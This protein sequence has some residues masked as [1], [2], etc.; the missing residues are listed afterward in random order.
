MEKYRDSYYF[1]DAKT[2]EHFFV[3]CSFLATEQ[4]K[5]FKIDFSPAMITR[6]D[7]YLK[8]NE[9]RIKQG[10]VVEIPVDLLRRV[11]DCFFLGNRNPAVELAQQ[12]AF[13]ARESVESGVDF[14]DVWK[15][16]TGE[17][18]EQV[19]TFIGKNLQGNEYVW[20]FPNYVFGFYNQ[21]QARFVF[22][23]EC[24]TPPEERFFRHNSKTL[25]AMLKSGKIKTAIFPEQSALR[26]LNFVNEDKFEDARAEAKLMLSCAIDFYEGRKNYELAIGSSLK[27]FEEKQDLLEEDENDCAEEFDDETD[28]LDDGDDSDLGI[29]DKFDLGIDDSNF[30]TGLDEGWRE[31]L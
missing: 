4:K 8:A 3:P 7:A 5:G 6:V 24:R 10:D 2:G 21:A 11:S 28:D 14:E 1:F 17:G 13:I 16:H 26:F 15:C 29:P 23:A 20:R 9:K 18:I 12:I 25:D 31:S 19:V 30:D 27:D 22:D